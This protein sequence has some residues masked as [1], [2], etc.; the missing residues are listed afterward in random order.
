MLVSVKA[1]SR[2]KSRDVFGWQAVFLFELKGEIRRLPLKKPP[3]F[4]FELEDTKP[5]SSS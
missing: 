1:L 4:V 5:V 3:G 2:K